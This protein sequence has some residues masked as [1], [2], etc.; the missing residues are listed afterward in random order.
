M[1]FANSDYDKPSIIEA[2]SRVDIYIS[3]LKLEIKRGVPK[4]LGV[5]CM[6]FNYVMN[7]FSSNNDSQITRPIFT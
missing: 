4:E 6:M 3:L 7:D 2:I 1:Q 5:F